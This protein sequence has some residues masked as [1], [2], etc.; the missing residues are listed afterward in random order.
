MQDYW[1]VD[2]KTIV[3]VA[4]KGSRGTCEYNRILRSYNTCTR[5]TT[6]IVNGDAPDAAHY[7]S[8]S[9]TCVACYQ[10]S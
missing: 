6:C 10:L 7:D 8:V 3:L 5:D 1:S 4:D 9:N 2:D